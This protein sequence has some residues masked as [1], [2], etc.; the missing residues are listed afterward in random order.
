M[1]DKQ[2]TPSPKLPTGI[3]TMVPGDLKR[4][5]NG[6]NNLPTFMNPPPPPP[7]KDVP[8]DTK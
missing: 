5:K 2:K 1:S 6:N 7:P 3:T 8:K 4:V